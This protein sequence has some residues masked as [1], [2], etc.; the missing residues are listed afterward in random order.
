MSVQIVQTERIYHE[1]TCCVCLDST[2]SNNSFSS[3]NC[4]VD[5]PEIICNK[6]HSHMIEQGDNRPLCRA[7]PRTRLYINRSNITYFA[8]GRTFF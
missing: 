1:D 8:N 5:H 6:C 2:P 7:I 3:W 4:T